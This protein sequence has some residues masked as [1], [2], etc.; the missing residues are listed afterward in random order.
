M[1]KDPD[2]PYT[3]VPEYNEEDAPLFDDYTDGDIW[4]D[5]EAIQEEVSKTTKKSKIVSTK[6]EKRKK[7]IFILRFVSLPHGFFAENKKRLF[8][9]K[10]KKRLPLKKIAVYNCKFFG[11]SKHSGIRT[12]F[13]PKP[14]ILGD[15]ILRLVSN[16]TWLSCRY[17]RIVYTE[18]QKEVSEKNQEAENTQDFVLVD[19]AEKELMRQEK[20]KRNYRREKIEYEKVR[21]ERVREQERLILED[22]K[23][24]RNKLSR[25]LFAAHEQ[26]T[27]IGEYRK[28][29][30]K[31]CI[32]DEIVLMGKK[33]IANFT[34][35]SGAAKNT[36]CEIN[37]YLSLYFSLYLFD[38]N[39]NFYKTARFLIEYAA[40]LGF[41]GIAYRNN[42][43]RKVNY[44][45]FSTRGFQMGKSKTM[46]IEPPERIENE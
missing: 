46:V 20:E 27:A 30:L 38:V 32:V 11:K 24:Q 3:F 12:K 1:N 5:D 42:F 25:L 7:S 39:S 23:K 36:A 28:L 6:K 15:A 40:K 26:L 35:I 2:D 13:L 29:N 31:E 21:A 44:V 37:R 16:Q 18:F 4:R 34:T 10:T 43:D 45:F 9:A 8:F 17:E 41:D 14:L 33:K 22:A 19:N